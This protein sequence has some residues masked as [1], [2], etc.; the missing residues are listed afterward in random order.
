MVLVALTGIMLVQGQTTPKLALDLA[1]GTTVTL[2]A[3]TESGKNPPNSQM[4]QAINII[5]D[6]VNGL[7]VSEADVTKQG[8]NHIVVSVPGTENQ[9]RIVDQIGTTAQLQFR[10]AFAVAAEIGRAHV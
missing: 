7:G 10:Q 8:D 4:G 2:T 6:R 5:R 1:G 9:K 3:V